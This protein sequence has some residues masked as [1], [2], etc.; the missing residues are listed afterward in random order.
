MLELLRQKFY[1]DRKLYE[2]LLGTGDALLIEGNNWGDTFW[3]QV[4]GQGSNMLGTML[5]L[6]RGEIAANSEEVK[7][8]AVP[9]FE[10]AES[11]TIPYRYLWEP[12]F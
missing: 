11:G 7:S 6:V 10:E 5:M 3:G 2:A 4:N 12:P 1:Y 9:N 8:N